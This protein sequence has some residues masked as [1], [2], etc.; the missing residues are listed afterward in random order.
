MFDGWLPK[1]VKI[2]EENYLIPSKLKK[3]VRE[4]ND[5]FIQSIHP[6]K[7]CLGAM[8]GVGGVPHKEKLENAG[9]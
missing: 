1:I 5:S 7:I 8:C 3:I 9:Q 4:K 2:G 6:S